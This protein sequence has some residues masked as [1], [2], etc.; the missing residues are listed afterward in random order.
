MANDAVTTGGTQ[1]DGE[2]AWLAD[3]ADALAES[4]DIRM[5]LGPDGSVTA[6]NQLGESGPGERGAVY[7]GSLGEPGNW[8][9]EEACPDDEPGNELVTVEVVVDAAGTT[10]VI[11]QAAPSP[12]RAQVVP[13]WATDRRVLLP[14]LGGRTVDGVALVT[15][16]VVRAPWYALRGLGVVARGMGRWIVRAEDDEQHRADLAA[17]GSVRARG[18]LRAVRTRGRVVRFV[19]AMLPAGAVMAWLEF[20]QWGLVPAVTIAGALAALTIAGWRAGRVERSPREAAALRRKIPALSRPFVSE[21]LAIVGC[22]PVAMPSGGLAAPVI[23]SSAPTRG[24]EVMVIDLPPGVAVSR[25]LK[26]HEEF[27]QALGRRPSASCSRRSRAS[28]PAGSSCSWRPSGSTRRT[29]PSGPG[30]TG[31]GVRSSTGCRSGSTRAAVTSSCR[32]SRQTA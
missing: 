31:S 29:R 28:P 19:G 20:G 8:E 5:F 23:V 32:C 14:W 24:G 1:D 17:A 3:A 9:W 27:A 26:R 21:A 22:G 30:A 10:E 13:S 16:H 18:R 25:L 7:L 12:E 4:G 15:F 6:E 2:L 11:A